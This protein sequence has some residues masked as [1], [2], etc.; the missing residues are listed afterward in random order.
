MM[1]E[2]IQPIVMP[3]WGLAMQEGML[4]AWQV[5]EGQE[6]QKGQEIADIETSKIANVFESP[7]AGPLRR[8]LVG[9]GE[10]VAV[11]ALLAVVADGSV[12]DAAIDAFVSDFQARFAESQAATAAGKGPEPAFVEV[13]GR[14]LRYLKLGDAEGVPVVFVHGFG[15]DLNNWL[16]NQPALA[17]KHTTY[18]VDLPGHGGSS[19]EVGAG[20]VQAMAAA[21]L[22]LLAALDVHRAHLVGHSMG[23]AV[24]LDLALHHPEHVASTTLICPAGLGPEIAMEYIDGFIAAS[25][26]KKLEPVLQMLVAN[27]ALVTGEMIEDILKYKRL[28][29][30]DQAL[31]TMRDALFPGDQQ[32]LVLKGHLASARHPLQV[33]WGR[34]D[35]VVPAAH[36]QGLPEQ[37]RVTVFDDAGHLAHME[38]AA[39]V[40]ALIEAQVAAA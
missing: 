2:L 37:V 26:R 7:V 4:A 15:G 19:K 25:R 20:T 40:N 30:V 12:P 36:G 27:P 34:Q 31:K 10:T 8:R 38:K 18:A 14:R 5:E 22:S 35:R 21:L 24:A 11:G 28:D 29:G 32:A 1:S 16:F 9:E 13:D 39:E 3:K 17:E 33:I 6:V 23:G